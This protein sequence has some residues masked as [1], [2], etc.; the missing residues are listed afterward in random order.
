MLQIIKAILKDSDDLTSI[1]LLFANRT[2]DDIL[3][4]ED[5]E[6][7]R[8]KYPHRVK[9]WYTLDSAPE[10]RYKKRD[11]LEVNLKRKVLGKDSKAR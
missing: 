8:D 5:L 1:C 7:I 3:C 9:L 6:S 11:Q 4:R 2:V 10:G